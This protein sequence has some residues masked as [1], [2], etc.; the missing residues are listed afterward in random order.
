MSG[1]VD[2]E[3]YRRAWERHGD[4]D[5]YF[6]PEFLHASAIGADA[7][8]AA[9][10]HDGVLYPFLV[11]PLPGG[12]C[13]LTSGYGFGGPSAPGDWRGAF[14]EACAERG[15]VSEFVR[16][17]PVRGNQR[18]AGDDI[19]VTRVQEMV[20][21]DVH[22]TDEELIQR[23]LPQA[24]NKLRKAVRA[25]LGV[26]ESRDFDR[27]SRL[28][29]AAM[30]HLGADESYLF[31]PEYFQ[32]LDDLGASLTMLDAGEA[33]A[34][35]LSG[36]GAMHYFLA[37]STDDGRRHAATNLIINE[38]MRRARDAGL[39]VLNLGGGLREGDSLHDFKT[40]FGPGRAPYCVGSA[41]HDE[42][43]YRELCAGAESES[44]GGFFPAYRRPA[45]TRV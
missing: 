9:F 2:I 13:D 32:A 18:F 7:E 19:T 17:H 14:R 10:V 25:G 4:G 36:A 21:L 35:F 30:R 5:A 20:V 26:E 28:Y 11:R 1:W 42:A 16:F 38:A 22:G 43:A 24:R 31:G 39:Q 29:T 8:P 41:V 6:T 45:E 23:M 27:F 15:V 40:S 44:A 34:L 37:A 3:G 12:R 33:V